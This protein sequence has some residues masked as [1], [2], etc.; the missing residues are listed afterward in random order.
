MDAPPPFHSLKRSPAVF[1]AV[2]RQFAFW[3]FWG[4][5]LVAGVSLGLTGYSALPIM[6][7]VAG[8]GLGVGLAMR[9]LQHGFVH[10]GLG[11]CNVV[12]L[13][14]L[15]LSAALLAPLVHA[16]AWHWAVFGVAALALALDGAD[17]WLARRE[18]R[19]SDFGARFDMEVD[20]AL[21]LIL[22]LNIWAAGTAGAL[23]LLIGLPRYVFVASARGLPWLNGALPERFSRKAVCVFQIA[24]LMALLLPVWPAGVGALLA[25][26]IAAA[27]L[28]SFGRDVIWL[29]RHRA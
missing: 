2:R 24:G 15:A 27:L 16:V 22:A 1:G 17:G 6:V 20:S 10:P 23:V 25:G 18:G 11:L 9:A 29:W 26:A 7:A 5:G 19:V 28:W 13:A 14:R 21:A 8:Y 4:L 3:A 12:T